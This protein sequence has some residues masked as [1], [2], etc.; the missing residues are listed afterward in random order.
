MLVLLL[1]VL[2][3]VVTALV[4]RR[5]APAP[6][7]RVPRCV[8]GARATGAASACPAVPPAY[9]RAGA[10]LR[11]VAG[12]AG[13]GAAA[14]YAWG[15]LSVAWAVVEAEDGG[16]ASAPMAPCRTGAEPER[17]ARVV[18]Y[19]ASYLPLGFLC[20][21]GDGD[22]Y[23]SGEIPGYANPGVAVLGLT[24]AAGAVGAGCAGELGARAAARARRE[25][26]SGPSAPPYGRT[27]RP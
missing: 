7:E 27:E 22:G 12:C 20:E 15:A 13:V 25:R 3:A 5:A 17:A 16:T 1:L 2:I 11:A 24:A 9:R 21:T 6:P 23:D 10:R 18:D 4:L 14:L 19:S 26:G 8:R